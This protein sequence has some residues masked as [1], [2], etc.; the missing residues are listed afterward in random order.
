MTMNGTP[1]GFT[2]TNRA[3]FIVVEEPQTLR[4]RVRHGFIDVAADRDDN[5]LLVTVHRTRNGTSQLVGTA[6]VI[7][8]NER[9]SYTPCYRDDNGVIFIR[10]RYLRRIVAAIADQLWETAELPK[11]VRRQTEWW[12]LPTPLRD[13]LVFNAA[14]ANDV[15]PIQAPWTVTV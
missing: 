2:E 8:T 5:D 3:T 10:D 12:T 1:L 9:Y 14:E 13:T 7:P 4:Y 15:S 11:R 6:R